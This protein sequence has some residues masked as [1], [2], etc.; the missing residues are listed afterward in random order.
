MAGFKRIVVIGAS[1][2]GLPVITQLV[3]QLRPDLNIAVFVVLHIS[4]NALADV[5][6][7]RLGSKSAFKCEVA[8]HEAEIKKG[9][10]YFAPPDSHLTLIKDKML[11]TAGPPENKWRP[12]IDVLFRSAAATYNTRA[13]GIILTGLLDDGTAGM[14]AIKRCG[15]ICIV[16]EPA[17]AQFDAMPFNVLYNVDVD[18]RIPASDIPYVLDDL[19][20]KPVPPEMEPPA[21]IRIEAEIN[22]RMTSNINRLSDIGSHS[23][24]TCPDCGGNLWE[25]NDGIIKRYRCHTGHAYTE[26][27]LLESK[28]EQLE[29][30]LWVAIRLLEE[31]RNLLNAVAGHESNVDERSAAE[32]Q[33]RAEEYKNHIARLKQMLIAVNNYGDMQKK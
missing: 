8:T 26:K 7:Q 2:G 10:L 6:V 18:Y 13:I 12:S 11:L 21:D 17:E 29:E 20:T 28:S 33:A 24:Y 5:I 16:Q 14:R 4:R 22:I 19:D 31:R 32:K 23:N 15:G 3:S 30:S 9:H 25:I 1:A 27:L